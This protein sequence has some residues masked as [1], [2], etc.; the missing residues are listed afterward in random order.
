MQLVIM[1]PT[2]VRHYKMMARVCLSVCLADS[3][4][5]RLNSR[6]DR[7]KKLKIGRMEAYHTSNQYTYLE[8][9]RSKVEVTRPIN[10]VI[11]CRSWHYNF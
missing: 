2:S 8:V 5:P 3:R 9:K 10:T 6:T 4:V 1:Q 11:Q 7:T